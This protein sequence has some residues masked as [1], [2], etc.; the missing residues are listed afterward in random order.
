M[1]LF[2]D[3]M[4]ENIAERREEFQKMNKSAFVL[5]STGEVGKELVR[6]LVMS[7]VF[8]R[9]VL[10]GRREVNY[11]DE[12]YKDVVGCTL[13]LLSEFDFKCANILGVESPWCHLDS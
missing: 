3:R 7:K 2:L 1:N 12:A 4:A 9:V 8:S 6:E 5:G 10:I 13:I 11:E